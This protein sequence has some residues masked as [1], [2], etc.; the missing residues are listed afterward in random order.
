MVISM[1]LLR[2]IA[3]LIKNYLRLALRLPEM[4]AM[5]RQLDQKMMRLAIEES[6][7]SIPVP[8]AYCVGA[9]LVQHCHEDTTI[10]ATGFSRE[11][12]GNTH[13][14]ECCLLKLKDST[15]AK[16]AHIYTTMEPCGERLSGKTPCA[17][18][19]IEA[20]VARV[21]CGIREPKHFISNCLG[22]DQL[23]E[24]GIIVDYLEGFEG[25]FH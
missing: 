24:A 22:T 11:I 17:T 21:I 23:R 8:S 25:E 3:I 16:G 5:Q 20:G 12:E 15:L 1:V 14:E 9:V 10:L 18:R 6:K 7:K 4:S 2:Y 13:A 19:L